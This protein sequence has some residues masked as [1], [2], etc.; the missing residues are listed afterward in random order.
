MQIQASDELLYTLYNQAEAFVFPS[1]YEGFGIP[2]LEAYACHCPAIISNTSCF[3]EIAS[4]AAAYFNPYSEMEI[5][6]TIA[7][8]IYNQTLRAE[9]IYKGSERLKLYSWEKLRF[10]QKK[11]IKK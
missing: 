2:I 8:V 1:L 10:K 11:Y 5:A 7:N 4:D 6:D 9:L 3:P